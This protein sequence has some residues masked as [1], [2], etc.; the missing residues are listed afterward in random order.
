M[1]NFDH[2][3]RVNAQYFKHFTSAYDADRKLYDLLLAEGYNLHGVCC[4]F[5]PISVNTD[6]DRIFGED[7]NRSVIRMFE[8]MAYFDLPKEAKQFS[9]MGQLWLDKFHIYI[10]KRH[11][12]SASR[13]GPQKQPFYY[14]SGYLP[15]IG[16][17]LESKYN[18]VYYEV[19]SVKEQEHQFLQHQHSWD[20]TVRVFVDKH[21]SVSPS[22]SGDVGSLIEYTD[23][24]DLFDI[25]GFVDKVKPVVVFSTS[26][27]FCSPKDPFN[28]W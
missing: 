8:F 4:N 15:K 1:G 7:N 25:A 2:F 21:I 27:E 28:D 24:S 17:M 12:D 11:F 6:Y 3:S 26:A 5:F 10:S 20:L 16:D 14:T 22:V 23:Q 19:M 9:T 13:F 18:N